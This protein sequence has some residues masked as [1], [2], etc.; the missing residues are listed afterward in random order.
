VAQLSIHLIMRVER[1][2][3]VLRNAALAALVVLPLFGYIL[4]VM[5][6]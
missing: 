5:D 6:F 2:S 1:N 3:A 4:N